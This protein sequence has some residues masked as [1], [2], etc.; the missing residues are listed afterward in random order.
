LSLKTAVKI[1]LQLTKRLA[2]LHSVG[3]VHRDL[4]PANLLHGLRS[5]KNILYLIDF[6]L[7]KKYKSELVV[8]H[9]SA[10]NFVGTPGYSA[11]ASH[12]CMDM[13]PKDDLE[14]MLYVIAKLIL[15]KLPWDL[16]AKRK[17]INKDKIR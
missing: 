4:K 1:A 10:V 12:M 13:G 16:Y 7:C 17:A 2:A 15:G 6:G 3:W 5:K 14:S 8:S 11:L 9:R